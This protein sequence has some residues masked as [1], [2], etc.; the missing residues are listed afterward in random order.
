MRIEFIK[1]KFPEVILHQSLLSFNNDFG[2]VYQSEINVLVPEAGLRG[3]RR[4]LCTS[5]RPDLTNEM[6]SD[7]RIQSRGVILWRNHVDVLHDAHAG[8]PARAASRARITIN[9][10]TCQAIEQFMAPA[11]EAA[12][13]AYTLVVNQGPGRPRC[14]PRTRACSSTSADFYTVRRG[15]RPRR[16]ATSRPTGH[17]ASVPGEGRG[18]TWPKMEGG[19][20]RANLMNVFWS[21]KITPP[22]ASR[23][24]GQGRRHHRRLHRRVRRDGRVRPGR[25]RA[26]WSTK[27]SRSTSRVRAGCSPAEPL[28]QPRSVRRIGPIR[29][30]PANRTLIVPHLTS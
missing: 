11:G 2:K 12:A 24:C 30:V 3:R 22:L 18:A 10:Y 1:E 8:W 20:T 27:A 9:S 28:T 4:C 13:N 21:M 29:S 17:G 26:I 16:S 23:R 7:P 5:R 15:R 14:T 25:P 19:L 6:T